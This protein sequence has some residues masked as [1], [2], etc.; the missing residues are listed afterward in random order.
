[1]RS[2]EA[3]VSAVERKRREC[4]VMALSSQVAED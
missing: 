3:R 1:M 2:D 4:A